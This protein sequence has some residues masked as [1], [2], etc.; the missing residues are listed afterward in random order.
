M[1]HFIAL[2]SILLWSIFS[3]PLLAQQNDFTKDFIERL[4]NSKTYLI[5]MAESMPENH[6]SFRAT[7]ETMSFEEHLM[8]IAWTLDWQ[9]QTLLGGR[10]PRDRKTDKELIVGQKSKSEMIAAVK[11][12]FDQSIKLI[13]E[14]NSI[15]LNEKMSLLGF[16]RS[17]R[18]VLLLLADHITHHRGQMIVSMRLNEITPPS[19]AS[20]Q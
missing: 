15:Q 20:Y 9:S 7:A 12:T 17:K 10:A 8:H 6:F 3:P 1:K 11:N 16:N 4:E 14:L 19:Y 13:S 2:A 5:L 18:Q